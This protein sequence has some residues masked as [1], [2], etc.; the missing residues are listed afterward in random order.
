MTEET[1]L[2]YEASLLPTVRAP[3]TPGLRPARLPPPEIA[4]ARPRTF[5]P[6]SARHTRPQVRALAAD[7][8]YAALSELVSV[9]A[10]GSLAQYE[11]F[12]AAHGALVADLGLDHEKRC[13]GRNWGH[14]A[15]AGSVGRVRR[16]GARLGGGRV[17]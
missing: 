12:V 17:S 10:H 7:P 6:S 13:E 3:V 15:R 2:L 5:P 8:R 1:N 16:C 14:E 11:A 4:H 9:F